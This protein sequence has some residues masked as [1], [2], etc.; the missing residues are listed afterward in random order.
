[1]DCAFDSFSRKNAELTRARDRRI[2]Q[3]GLH[4]HFAD[5]LRRRNGNV[6][7]VVQGNIVGVDAV[8]LIT[9]LRHTRAIYRDIGRV[10]SDG[11]VSGAVTPGAS[12]SNCRKLC[13][14]NGSV[15]RLRASIVEA[16]SAPSLRTS[17]GASFTVTSTLLCAICY[18]NDEG[19][20]AYGIS[21]VDSVSMVRAYAVP[22]CC[23]ESR[24]F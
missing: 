21:E 10:A 22:V 24:L 7:E 9:I 23:S 11:A 13:V 20:K 14:G 4:V 6:C 15:S 8:D 5:A 1:M 3:R 18:A 17:G 16:S 19:Q 12:V 2:I